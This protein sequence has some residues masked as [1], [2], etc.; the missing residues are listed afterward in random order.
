MNMRHHVARVKYKIGR[1]GCK[2]NFCVIFAANY[3]RKDSTRT[4]HPR[5]KE[6]ATSINFTPIISCTWAIGWPMFA[7]L[8]SHHFENGTSRGRAPLI[9]IY[10]PLAS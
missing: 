9:G 2:T 3:L 7:I 8:R 6:P 1:I 5:A 10:F 4:D